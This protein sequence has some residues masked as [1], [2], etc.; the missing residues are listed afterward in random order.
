MQAQPQEGARGHLQAMMDETREWDADQQPH[1][2]VVRAWGEPTQQQR[3]PSYSP[4]PS[5]SPKRQEGDRSSPFVSSLHADLAPRTAAAVPAA[6]AQHHPAVPS[7]AHLSRQWNN[8]SV[9]QK[10]EQP[11]APPRESETLRSA[12]LLA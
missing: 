1:N 4:E 11:S 12:P 3:A 5:A 6:P 10:T 8:F 9:T 2:D 7:V